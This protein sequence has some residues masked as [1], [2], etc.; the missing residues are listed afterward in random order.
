MGDEPG[1]VAALPAVN[2]TFNGI[3]TLLLAAGYVMIRRGNRETH[4]RL[5][6]SAF[7]ASVLFLACYLVYHFA[8]HHYTGSGSKSFPREHSGRTFYLGILLT[9]VV[10]AA[11][12]PFLAGVTI[13]RA[14][15]QD[16]ARHRRIARITFPIW[17]YVSITGVIIYVMLYHWA[18]P[19]AA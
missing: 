6:L 2:A 12:V 13:F 15:K 9:H 16:W 18:L 4:K 7:G 19:V 17:L 10:L 3:A 5:M 8:L 11:A 1:W 14:W